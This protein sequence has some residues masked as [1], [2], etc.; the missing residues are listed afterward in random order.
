[1]PHSISSIPS[2]TVGR[3]Q[4][5]RTTVHFDAEFDRFSR[6]G[7]IRSSDQ[8][9]AEFRAYPLHFFVTCMSWLRFQIADDELS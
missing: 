6:F 9:L 5:I 2:A 3:S 7:I 8:G 4:I 1:M